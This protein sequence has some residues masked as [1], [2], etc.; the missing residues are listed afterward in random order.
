MP[1][2]WIAGYPARVKILFSPIFEDG[3]R[4]RNNCR[5][6]V[7]VGWMKHI[8]IQPVAFFSQEAYRL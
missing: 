5:P 7:P 4:L 3:T 8:E 2:L 1:K 6:K